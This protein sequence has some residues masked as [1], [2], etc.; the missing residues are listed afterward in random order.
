MN[1]NL[2]RPSS[3]G[4]E[5]DVATFSFLS[6]FIV[7]ALAVMLCIAFV[8]GAVEYELD[9][10]EIRIKQ[11]TG[12]GTV[13]LLIVSVPPCLIGLLFGSWFFRSIEHRLSSNQAIQIMVWA[14]SK[15]CLAIFL[16]WLA[17]VIFSIFSFALPHGVI[18]EWRQ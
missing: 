18:S 14:M 11:L 1:L 9:A 5:S 12:L 6:R 8:F 7:T 13:F 17:F 16:T 3:E 10:D 15:L 4:G 2:S